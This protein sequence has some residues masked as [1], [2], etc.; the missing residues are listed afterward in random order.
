MEQSSKTVGAAEAV[1]VWSDGS[2]R[3]CDP[4]PGQPPAGQVRSH[5]RTVWS[6]LLL[7]SNRPS[8]LNA[9]LLAG[10]RVPQPHRIV[11]AAAALSRLML[12]TWAPLMLDTPR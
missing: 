7:A 4:N 2:P 12:Y 10:G 1:S 6:S 9:T 5:S 8:G 3:C 11:G